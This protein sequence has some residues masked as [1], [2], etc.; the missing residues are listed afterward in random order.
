MI[1]N[2]DGPTQSRLVSSQ[3]EL[4]SILNQV[5]KDSVL[6]KSANLDETPEFQ[7][8]RKTQ[9]TLNEI[10]G[11]M[12]R[13]GYGIDGVTI[14]NMDMVYDPLVSGIGSLSRRK[15]QLVSQGMTLAAADNLLQR[16]LNKK[17]QSGSIVSL[18]DLFSSQK[19]KTAL[20]NADLSKDVCLNFQS[21]MPSIP[22][23]GQSQAEDLISATRLKPIRP[24]MG[25]MQV[26]LFST[27]PKEAAEPQQEEPKTM[28]SRFFAFLQRAEDI[29][30]K[31]EQKEEKLN[32]EIEEGDISFE[33]SGLQAGDKSEQ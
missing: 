23:Y 5:N 25:Q 17:A 2:A 4:E 24:V 29:D 1:N 31:V 8:L 7:R 16:Y 6:G 26:R 12:F 32:F 33:K 11:D 3:A 18:M 22:L 9:F 28:K 20:N 10:V 13:E 21:Q 27:D 15:Q 30:K 19:A 14:D